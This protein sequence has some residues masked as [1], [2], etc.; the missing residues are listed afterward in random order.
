MISK[1]NSTKVENGSGILPPP[2]GYVKE[3]A[4]LCGCDRTTVHNALRK[5]M[6]GRKSDLVRNM[7]RVKYC[8]K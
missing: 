5:N 7:Y 2:P 3:L 6:P 4:M 8:N 1:N